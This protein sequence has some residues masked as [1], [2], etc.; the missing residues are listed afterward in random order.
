[1]PI[2]DLLKKKDKFGEK[3]PS[4]QGAAEEPAFKIYRSDTNTHELIS[5]PTF[6]DD[7][8]TPGSADGSGDSRGNRLFKNRNRSTSAASGASASSHTSDR[9]TSKTSSSKRISQRLHLR[10]SDVTSAS[11]PNDLPAITVDG[12]EDGGEG[13]ESQW[14]KRATILARKNEES[15]S[16][17]TTP[18]GSVADIGRFSDMTLGGSHK[19]DRSVSSKKTDDNIQEAIRLHESGELETSTRMFGRLADPNGEN[20]ALS[21]VL[22]GLALRYVQWH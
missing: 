20:N 16:R 22:Y 5:P 10:K 12:N 17:P 6:A 19:R 15:R 4:A 8:N 13:A 14:E 3:E 1:M 7:S 11:V 9:S 2:R 21:Q 18:S